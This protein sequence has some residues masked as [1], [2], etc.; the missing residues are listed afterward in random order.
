MN[1]KVRSCVHKKD[2]VGPVDE[3]WCEM[4]A[5]MPWESDAYIEIKGWEGVRWWRGKRNQ[6]VGR[7]FVRL[8]SWRKCQKPCNGA[9]G[10]TQ[11]VPGGKSISSDSDWGQEDAKQ[12]KT[13]I[14]GFC[15]KKHWSTYSFW[16]KK[17][18]GFVLYHNFEQWLWGKMTWKKKKKKEKWVGCK[19][20]ARI[21][22]NAKHQT[23]SDFRC[24]NTFKD[25]YLQPSSV[26]VKADPE[27]G[28]LSFLPHWVS[29]W[30]VYSTFSQAWL[31]EAENCE[32]SQPHFN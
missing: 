25:F 2:S 29:L 8:S 20:Q 28:H 1:S 19:K 16:S 18:V 4:L 14:Q 13:K 24:L 6:C 21:W 7:S 12:N 11:Q 23:F 22:D 9:V 31:K 3:T 15:S 26:V 27:L 10:A 32:H 5:K 30:G 17:A